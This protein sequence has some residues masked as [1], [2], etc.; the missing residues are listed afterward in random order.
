MF[1]LFLSLPLFPPSLLLLFLL[2]PLL[3]LIW[4]SLELLYP[5]V[6]LFL[7]EQV[8]QRI[9]QMRLQDSVE[10]LFGDLFPEK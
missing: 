6:L 2:F 7:L 5:L 9:G 1:E 3:L 8:N 4:P 10:R